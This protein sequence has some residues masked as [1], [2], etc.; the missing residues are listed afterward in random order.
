M[1]NLMTGAGVRRRALC[2]ATGAL[3]AGCAA[4][5]PATAPATMP[6]S[7]PA[8]VPANEPANEPVN[9][10]TAGANFARPV[11]LAPD[12]V[13]AVAAPPAGFDAARPG[14][15]Q[16]AVTEF[17]YHSAVTG[18]Q[19][20]AK[21]YLPPGY[22]PQRRYPVLY[23]LHGIGGNE[24]EWHWYVRA[25]AVLDNLM[26]DGKVAPMIVVMPNG[27]A[28]AD[29]RAPPPERTFTQE[30]AS[31]FALFEQDLLA[32]LIPAV[33]RRYPVMAGREQRAIAG[34]SMGGGQA[35]N[36]GLGHPDTFGWV[37]G[38]SAAPNTHPARIAAPARLLYL[39]CGNKDGLINVSQGLHRRLRQQGVPHVWHVDD[40]GHSRESWAENLYHFAQLLFRPS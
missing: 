32:S 33:E 14:V 4:T 20:N 36:F 22:D 7:V 17:T 39:S 34:L 2:V 40:Y 24:H 5:G 9:A 35:L 28:L 29:D 27:R 23:L 18:R 21:V 15:A 26:A 25:P 10:A 30:N 16:G 8:D 31:G 1:K 3:L 11:V 38:F 12:D 13:R 37:A 19:R 6:A